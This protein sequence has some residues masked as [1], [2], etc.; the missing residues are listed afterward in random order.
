MRY[1]HFVNNVKDLPRYS[2]GKESITELRDNNQDG[3]SPVCPSLIEE[4]RCFSLPSSPAKR[5]SPAK[6]K[7]FYISK[8]NRNSDLTPRAKGKK[9]LRRLENCMAVTLSPLTDMIR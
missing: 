3:S 7:Q 6:K 9:S 2:A 1:H 4:R 5:V 8:A